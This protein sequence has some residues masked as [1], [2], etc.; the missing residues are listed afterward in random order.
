MKKI[1]TSILFALAMGVYA[2]GQANPIIFSED[3]RS[4][5]PG[6]FPG[7]FE[8]PI[9]WTTESTNGADWHMWAEESFPSGTATY[10]G[11]ACAGI[12]VNPFS[13]NDSWLF[14]PSFTLESG[15]TYEISFRRAIFGTSAQ[16]RTV[17]LTTTIGTGA[18]ASSV[19]DTIYS[20]E[21]VAER[22]D[23]ELVTYLFTPDMDGTYYLGF[24]SESEGGGVGVNLTN[25][26]TYIDDILVKEQI[27]DPQG[28]IFFED[29]SEYATGSSNFPTG[30]LVRTISATNWSLFNVIPGG[31]AYSGVVSAGVG[32]SFPNTAN[33]SWL[34]TPGFS[35][36][37]GKIYDLSFWTA[38][39]GT[40]VQT[41]TVAFTATI[42]TGQHEDDVVETIYVDV[43]EGSIKN[44][45]RIV[46]M[47]T[48]DADGT[49]YLGFHSGSMAGGAG[50]NATNY[51]T[52]V[53]HILVE[54]HVPP[55]VCNAPGSL[56]VAQTYV[57]STFTWTGDA[58]SYDFM[59]WDKD[60]DILVHSQRV[61]NATISLNRSFFQGDKAYR[62]GVAGVCGALFS[63]TAYSEFTALR[64]T[65][66]F[67]MTIGMQPVEGSTETNMSAAFPLQLTIT[68]FSPSTA[69]D[70]AFKV[71][72]NDTLTV[73]DTLRATINPNGAS[74]QVFCTLN[75]SAPGAYNLIAVIDDARDMNPLN[76]TATRSF[77]N[78]RVD[79]GVT[80]LISPVSGNL[81]TNTEQVR[82][83]VTNYGTDTLRSFSFGVRLNDVSA[84]SL[85]N[86]QTAIAPNESAV[87]DH[88]QTLDLSEF[89]THKVTA[90]VS[91][92]QGSNIAIDTIHEM[93]TNLPP[94]DYKDALV[95]E[96]LDP[97]IPVGLTKMENIRVVIR[98]NSAESVTNLPVTLTVN[99]EV[100]ASDTIAGPI[101]GIGS[102]YTHTFTNV[103][104][105]EITTYTLQAFTS[106][107]GDMIPENDT[108]TKLI[109]TLKT[110]PDIPFF[111]DFDDT[112]VNAL[113]EGWTRQ[114]VPGSGGAWLVG[115]S[116]QLDGVLEPRYAYITSGWA[117]RDAWLF[118][119]G[120]VLQ[121]GHSYRMQ[122]DLYTNRQSHHTQY[123]KL[124]VNIGNQA[125]P[126]A[127]MD[128]LFVSEEK[129]YD[130]ER[131]SFLFT[132][133]TTDFY[134]IGF[135]AVSP[136][137][138]GHIVIDNVSIDIEI[139]NSMEI[140][141]DQFPFTQIP[142]DMA[143]PALSA[144]AHNIGK[145]AQ[146]NVNLSVMLNNQPLGVSNT[147][148]N[149]DAGQISDAMTIPVT[150]PDIFSGINTLLYSVNGGAGNDDTVP[151]NS[152]E[153]R[154][155]GTESTLAMDAVTDLFEGVG[156]AV[157]NEMVGN[158]FPISQDI[159]LSQ[160]VIGFASAATMD[161]TIELYRIT[162]TSGSIGRLSYD[163]SAPLFKHAAVRDAEGFITITIPETELKAGESYF[164]GV[165]RTATLLHDVACDKDPN[166][167]NYSGSDGILTPH[168]LIGRQAGALAIRMILNESEPTQTLP[169]HIENQ[170]IVIYPNPVNDVLHIQT[171]QTI[172]Q[173]FVLDL[174]GRV[175][176]Q[177]QGDRKTVD[178]Q[179]IPS[180]NYIVR[181]HTKTTIVPIKIVKQ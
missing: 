53:D 9:G 77:R 113:P 169:I 74:A 2:N 79:Y 97:H 4:A 129:L 49:Y 161:Y 78:N 119:R 165:N 23:W 64:D 101:A 108:A 80:A 181:I 128:T 111:E 8:F 149:L 146:T 27:Q 38:I 66:D 114:A 20:D 58:N 148:N 48:P 99:G 115:S 25:Y 56:S 63:D 51:R 73:Y 112:P 44:W 116:F 83:E 42:G 87:L 176:L 127:M 145:L 180:G 138:L 35:L 105:S 159:T 158:V 98:N 155:E 150:K 154:F 151:R 133:P 33:N 15:K 47:F 19:V 171:E 157:A 45:E 30:W 122:F 3:F 168:N 54:E 124:I 175:M 130:M 93:I 22:V 1:I 100:R 13:T 147:I 152:V 29:F 50:A 164:L 95:T 144:K 34:F 123:E 37:A 167:T 139:L 102:Y 136:A 153:F 10:S 163:R 75:L 118:S 104:L 174:T 41:R 55:T 61:N 43:R 134:Y 103:D 6:A 109:T 173:I 24:Y 120:I 125:T 14:S 57:T 31:A 156:S 94:M 107:E 81:L 72:I 52:Y 106:L 82:I 89:G 162:G 60:E 143:L 166:R 85:Q 172:K 76:D 170:N 59:L 160:V 91:H 26:R 92:V 179:S 88:D 135:H 32:A 178:L 142:V 90:F 36:E 18:N 86:V 117:A 132:A 11:V 84:G 96:I 121:A 46:Y 70:I 62:F 17:K 16:T 12:G 126:V 71:I 21:R 39:F 141:A 68:N 7:T 5:P 67:R 131:I 110:S 65:F 137:D 69:S 40:S 140:L 28:P 177:L